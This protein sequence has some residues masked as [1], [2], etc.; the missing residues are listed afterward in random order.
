MRNCKLWLALSFLALA[1]R[2]TLSDIINYTRAGAEYGTTPKL[3]LPVLQN[4]LEID[5]DVNVIPNACILG[6]VNSD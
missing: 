5:E 1:L 6:D 4:R 2:K 3:Y